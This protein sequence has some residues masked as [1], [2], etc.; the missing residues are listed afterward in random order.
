MVLTQGDEEE[1]PSPLKPLIPHLKKRKSEQESPQDS[2]LFSHCGSRTMKCH[3]P[4]KLP[5]SAE[6]AGHR[7][8]PSSFPP[9][10]TVLNTSV[11]S[12]QGFSFFFSS[13]FSFYLF[14]C[15]FVYF[16]LRWVFIA[17]CALSLV[18][19]SGGYSSLRCLGFSL[20]WLL[21][22]QS[23]GFR[24]AG[25]SSC[26]TQAQQLWLAGSRS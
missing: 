7:G 4:R 13:F 25:F 23:T 6:C 1:D 21:L 12:P 8:R 26:D 22:L 18:V 5:F 9:H 2:S 15:L 24:H 20:Q 3:E 16:W 17:A 10:W 19:A 14:I 11:A